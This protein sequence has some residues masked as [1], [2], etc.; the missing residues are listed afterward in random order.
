ME[1]SRSLPRVTKSICASANMMWNRQNL[2]TDILCLIQQL[3]RLPAS[4]AD[5]V[6]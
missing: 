5:L 6:I 4:L 3:S 2:L 1:A